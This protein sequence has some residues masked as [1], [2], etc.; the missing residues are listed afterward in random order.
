M[1][2][3]YLDMRNFFRY[4][5][6]SRNP[7][8]ADKRLDEIDIHDVD[9]SFIASIT[10]TDIYGYLTY[11]SRD[12]LQ[13]QN[14]ENSDKGLSA[15]SRARKLATIRSFFNY[16][17][18]KRHLLENNPCKDVDTPK[19][20]KSLPRYLT[21]NECLSLLESVDGAHRERDYCILTLF[22]NLSLIHI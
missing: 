14:S 12:R 16:I 22:L 15:A 11:L 18:N 10:L 13:H 7:T 8:L 1:D 3:Y 19:Q 6:Q 20:M 5:K 9:L 21:L 2:E 4:L 17:C